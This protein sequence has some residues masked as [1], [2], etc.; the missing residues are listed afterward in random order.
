MQNRHDWIAILVILR[1]VFKRLE[2]VRECLFDTLL[3]VIIFQQ[4]H[5]N[6]RLFVKVQF[7]EICVLDLGQQVFHDA[8]SEVF[9]LKRNVSEQF[10][11]GI[12]R[13]FLIWDLLE[14][15]HTLPKKLQF[16]WVQF[17]KVV[18]VREGTLNRMLKWVSFL[19]LNE[20]AL[21]HKCWND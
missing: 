21:A 7:F 10:G 5:L 17:D 14:E 16:V 8:R 11:N 6:Q 19:R 12:A 3:H 13:E 2:K 9:V 1:L 18:L 4:N 15:R 20:A